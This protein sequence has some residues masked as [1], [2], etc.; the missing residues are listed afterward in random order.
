M[1]LLVFGWM[2]VGSIYI[3]AGWFRAGWRHRL[4]L[5]VYNA[6][7]MLALGMDLHALGMA[8]TT[9]GRLEQILRDGAS[10][11]TDDPVYWFGAGMVIAGKTFFV[12]VASLG[13]GR[14]YSRKFWWSYWASLA[15]WMA[16]SMWWYS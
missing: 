7:L 5:S 12:W 6:A 16:F 15:A 3:T 14:T 4:P 13:E 1:I 2:L 10:F 8:L 9:Y 11:G